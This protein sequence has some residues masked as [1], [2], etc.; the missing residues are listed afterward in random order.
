MKATLPVLLLL[1]IVLAFA[2]TACGD[3]NTLGAPTPTANAAEVASVTPVTQP[4]V[5]LGATAQ[6]NMLTAVINPTPV[7]DLTPPPGASATPS[8]TPTRTP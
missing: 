5:G 7:M 2:L 1:C 3:N 6:S 8:P 4:N